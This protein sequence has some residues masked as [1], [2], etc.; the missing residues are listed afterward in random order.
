A[1][2]SSGRRLIVRTNADASFV[3]QYAATIFPCCASKRASKSRYRSSAAPGY[4]GRELSTSFGRRWWIQTSSGNET[5]RSA[6]FRRS[7]LISPR[8]LGASTPS[9]A[10]AFTVALLLPRGRAAL[11]PESAR[12]VLGRGG[13]GAAKIPGDGRDRD[14]EGEE[15]PR[16]DAEGRGHHG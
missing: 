14:D 15:R 8:S 11:R 10:V 2:S 6:R 1:A 7:R 16:R 13:R 3:H 12:G 5:V 9:A 4:G